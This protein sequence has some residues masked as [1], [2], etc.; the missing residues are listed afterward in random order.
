MSHL[1]RFLAK[2]IEASKNI[3]TLDPAEC[4]HLRKVLR[5]KE[6]AIVEL[7]DGNGTVVHAELIDIKKDSIKASI[8]SSTLLKHSEPS[9]RF[10]LAVGA[11]KPSDIDDSLAELIELGVDEVH[12]F[13]QEGVAKSRLNDAVAERW[14]RVSL[15]ACK[16]SKRAFL[17]KIETHSSL[18]SAILR[19]GACKVKW[20]LEAGASI[21]V[22]DKSSDISGQGVGAVVG[23]ERGLTSR[24]LELCK[25]SM[26]IEVKLGAYVMRARTAILAIAAVVSAFR[27]S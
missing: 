21:S 12:V 14:Q 19:L 5:L 24:E 26:F 27:M 9:H 20:V 13:Q 25:K 18:E 8:D 11:L 10:M 4:E 22:A 17:P 1:F 6:G 7:F 16:Q 15:A 3:W 23:G 2:P